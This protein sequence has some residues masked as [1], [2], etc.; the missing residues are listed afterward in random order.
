M[1][2]QFHLKSYQIHP[3]GIYCFLFFLKKKGI[4]NSIFD[5]VCTI[6]NVQVQFNEITTLNCDR[7][8]YRHLTQTNQEF[9]GL[10]L[11]TICDIE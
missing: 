4:E 6:H 2:F 5:R 1:R 8:D 7:L 10:Q 11:T 9:E 3:F